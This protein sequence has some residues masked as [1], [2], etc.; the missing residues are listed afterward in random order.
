M[1]EYHIFSSITRWISQLR[2][3]KW[4]V[5]SCDQAT[6]D[7]ENVNDLLGPIV[8]CV[9][10]GRLSR[11]GCRMLLYNWPAISL[12]LP[13]ACPARK[14]ERAA[15]ARRQEAQVLPDESQRMQTKAS[16]SVAG[17]GR[18]LSA[19]KLP[20]CAPCQLA[21]TDWQL[22]L[23]QWKSRHIGSLLPISSSA[24]G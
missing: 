23:C 5:V 14:I 10:S 16:V 7:Y 3:V 19:V 20:L 11:S 4:P 2:P 8:H 21:Q 1:V 17:R 24:K 22:T 12:Y 9:A 15:S 13:I 6:D 18:R